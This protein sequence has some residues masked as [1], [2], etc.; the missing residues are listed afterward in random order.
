[1]PDFIPAPQLPQGMAEAL[2]NIKSRAG[3][4]WAALAQGLGQ[5]VATGA[6]NYK[7]KQ[8]N[9]PLTPE[10]I[11]TVQKGQVPGGLTREQGLSLAEKQA[12]QRAMLGKTLVPVTDSVREIYKLSG[13]Q[14]NP[15][16]TQVSAREFDAFSKLAQNAQKAALKPPSSYENMDGLIEGVHLFVTSGGKEGTDPAQIPGFGKNS[17]KS[18][19][20]ADLNKKYPDDFKGLAAAGRGD[21]AL[22]AGQRAEATAPSSAGMFKIR[23]M[24]ES[25]VPQLDNLVDAS[26]AVARGDVKLINTWAGKLGTALSQKDWS[27]LKKRA[28]IVADEFQAQIGAGSDAKLDLAKQLIDAADSPEVLKNAAAI[29]REAVKA[30]AAASKG[31][32]PTGKEIS[33]G[34]HNGGEADSAA[35]LQSAIDK[36]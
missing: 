31:G 36:L 27:N 1:M 5:N 6:Q 14:L 22:A 17:L 25:L 35:A 20:M 24:A 34:E 8:A 29:M 11:A 32:K 23:A 28:M 16:D 21:K 18:Q 2:I 7:A 15:D 19:M 13:H 12:Q 10:Q 4:P 3:D 26:D 30:R 33:G 9:K